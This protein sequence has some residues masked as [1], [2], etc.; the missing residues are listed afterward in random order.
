MQY[1]VDNPGRDVEIC[2]ILLETD[3]NLLPVVCNGS[4]MPCGDGA[5]FLRKF[6]F[7]FHLMRDFACCGLV[8]KRL[9]GIGSVLQ[10]FCGL[11]GIGSVL[12]VFCGLKGARRCSFFMRFVS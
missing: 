6:H 3:T 7:S 10:V 8:E 1:F 11:A 2:C 4:N 12:Q 9:A 5:I